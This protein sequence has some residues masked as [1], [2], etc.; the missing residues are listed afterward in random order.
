MTENTVILSLKLKIKKNHYVVF[1]LKKYDD[2]FVSLEK[3]ALCNK[4]KPELIKPLILKIFESLNK[5]YHLLNNKISLYD[6][7]YLKSLYKLWIKNK[8]YYDKKLSAI[9][10]NSN[11][12][13]EEDIKYNS[14]HSADEFSDNECNN[15]INSI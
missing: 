5:I 15:S 9:N 12:L 8:D 13:Y 11:S 10:Y 1:N 7:E 6:Q 14:Y 4:I 3:F 2:I